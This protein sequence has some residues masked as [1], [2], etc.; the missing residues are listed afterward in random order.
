M[1]E[2]ET[3]S[4]I[5]I[6]DTEDVSELF[7]KKQSEMSEDDA[8]RS[9]GASISVAIGQSI[10]VTRSEK[11]YADLLKSVREECEQG[12]SVAL[13]GN[14]KKKSSEADGDKDEKKDKEMEKEEEKEEEEEEEKDE[15]FFWSY[16]LKPR[17]TVLST[18]SKKCSAIANITILFRGR[19]DE[20]ILTIVDSAYLTFNDRVIDIASIAPNQDDRRVATF[21]GFPESQPFLFSCM[22]EEDELKI[23]IRFK[24][25]PKAFGKEMVRILADLFWFETQ[26]DFLHQSWIV[27]LKFDEGQELFY[28]CSK[29]PATL[30]TRGELGAPPDVLALRASRGWPHSMEFESEESD[31][32]ASKS[33]NSHESEKSSSSTR[34]KNEL[35]MRM[36]WQRR[37]EADAMEKRAKERAKSAIA[38]MT[39]TLHLRGRAYSD[40]DVFHIQRLF[41]ASSGMSP[42]GEALCAIEIARWKA[43]KQLLEDELA[44]LNKELIKGKEQKEEGEKEEKEKE[45]EKEKEI[46]EEEENDKNVHV[47]PI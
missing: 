29:T 45:N 10:D 19:A 5:V 25:C 34:R 26:D 38:S 35:K 20:G 4:R 44:L 2:F 18:I 37:L 24:K 41:G 14:W 7:K 36:E 13:Q 43:Q 39:G 33:Q 16:F 42:E 28:D 11:G 9:V 6:L 46:E 23:F 3:K 8:Y 21:R 30:T 31:S 32:D 1:D 15:N 17:D 40:E 27:P 12:L 47:M 22:S